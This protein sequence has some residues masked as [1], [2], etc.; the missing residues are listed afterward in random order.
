M[1]QSIKTGVLAR[2]AERAKL[3]QIIA[4][5]NEKKI[6]NTI[7]VIKANKAHYHAARHY[8][9]P[10]YCNLNQCLDN[11]ISFANINEYT[12]LNF[13]AFHYL[14]G[15]LDDIATFIKKISKKRLPID[16]QKSRMVYD[17]FKLI[18]VAACE[19]LAKE[20][21]IKALPNLN[22]ERLSLSPLTKHE[23]FRAIPID[24]RHF[25]RLTNMFVVDDFRYLQFFDPSKLI[26]LKTLSFSNI[27]I[28]DVL[29]FIAAL[30]Y[31][32]VLE[33]ENLQDFE[34]WDEIKNNT[35][36][37][38]TLSIHWNSNSTKFNPTTLPDFSI[39]MPNLSHLDFTQKNIYNFDNLTKL[40]KLN[41]LAIQNVGVQKPPVV[42]PLMPKL[43][44]LE[45]YL[46][47]NVDLTVI[48]QFKNL[49][50]LSISSCQLGDI[51]ILSDL[52]KLTFLDISYN[53]ISDISVLSK[54]KQLAQL[55]TIYNNIAD[56]S[57]LSQLENLM[58]LD[59]SHNKISDIS[60]LANLNKLR[61]IQ[62]RNNIL[63]VYPPLRISIWIDRY[64]NKNLFENL[65]EPQEVSGLRALILSKDKHNKALAWQIVLGMGW[66][67]VEFEALVHF[68]EKE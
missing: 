12:T 7:A 54:F 52:K 65:E 38:L 34:G 18:G 5:C 32:E 47:R 36:T 51:S 66:K 59:L 60:N 13:L 20:N 62:L 33:F 10:F 56:I 8:Y 63:T 4:S 9:K 27:N 26:S 48:N 28:C 57:V 46:L 42:L 21:Q 44:K 40:S 29:D 2:R 25:L 15:T 30:P 16:F 37:S 17:F 64:N 58:D 68:F 23:I 39:N 35:L 19:H 3:Y 61:R 43:K 1:R 11:I 41:H 14:R 53:E 6:F 45:L 24:F 50:W 31:L 55:Y 49:T 22:I 67:K